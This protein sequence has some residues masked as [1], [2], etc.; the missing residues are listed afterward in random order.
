MI[1]TVLAVI[2]TLL[3]SIASVGSDHRRALWM[4]GEARLRDASNDELEEHRSFT[5][6]S[7]LGEAG[8]SASTT[9][10]Q[11][12]PR[13]PAEA[14]STSA[15]SVGRAISTVTPPLS[16]MI[17]TVIPGTARGAAGP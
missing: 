5:E 12:S 15:R 8:N 9:E 14:F 13:P 17:G 11:S 7:F 6:F 10:Q 2:G 1:A 16:D 4:R 3:G